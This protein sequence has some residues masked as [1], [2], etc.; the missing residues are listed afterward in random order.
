MDLFAAQ[1]AEVMAP[2]AGVVTFA[3]VVVN[4]PTL[5]VATSSGLRLSFEPVLSSLGAGDLVLRGQQLGTLQGPTHCSGA[6]A[7][8]CLHWGVRRGEEYL[9]PLQFIFDLRP[10]VL[11]PLIE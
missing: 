11:L 2:T 5:T 4:R 10:S 8:S 9:D 1:G 7:K 6:P 3:G